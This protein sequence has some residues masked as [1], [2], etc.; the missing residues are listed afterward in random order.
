M[1]TP[2]DITSSS[3]ILSRTHFN[4]VF[5]PHSTKRH[6]SPRSPMTSPL[7]GPMASF[8]S[9]SYTSDSLTE[10]TTHSSLK[11]LLCL[12][13]GC[14]CLLVVLPRLLLLS[15]L[16]WFFPPSSMLLGNCPSSTWWGQ[17]TGGLL[18]RKGETEVSELGVHQHNWKGEYRIINNGNH[19]CIKLNMG[20]QDH[21]LG[22]RKLATRSLSFRQEFGRDYMKNMFSRRERPKTLALFKTYPMEVDMCHPQAQSLQSPLSSATQL[23]SW[24][25]R[26]FRY[27]RG[28]AKSN[29]KR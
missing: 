4:Q 9:S 21:P 5:V 22:S 8:L 1:S 15:L 26:I 29:K 25:S 23:I 11:P 2:I 24:Q 18:S 12:L 6:L 19:N 10:V 17:R 27:L 28:G 3:T 7:P 16:S 14:H 20:S 13:Q